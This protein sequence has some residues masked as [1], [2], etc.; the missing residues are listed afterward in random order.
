M[1]RFPS[2]IV[3]RY[4]DLCKKKILILSPLVRFPGTTPRVALLR[5]PTGGTALQKT[6]LTM[7]VM[8]RRSKEQEHEWL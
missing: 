2:G 8:P 4:M 5:E 3:G 6:I 1:E 7:R